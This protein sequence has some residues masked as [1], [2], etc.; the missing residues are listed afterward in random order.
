MRKTYHMNYRPYV[1]STCGINRK[2][3]C[4]Y[5]ATDSQGNVRC[6]KVAAQSD[7]LVPMPGATVEVDCHGIRDF[8]RVEQSLMNTKATDL[9][10]EYNS[11]HPKA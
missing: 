4:K 10:M 1:I 11:K 7:D 6:A 8:A 5:L 3:R 9:R 2:T